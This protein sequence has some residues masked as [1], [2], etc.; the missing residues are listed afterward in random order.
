M[1]EAWEPS[2]I[3]GVLPKFGEHQEGKVLNITSVF[4]GH[5]MWVVRFE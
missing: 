2:N 5:L 1:D 3:C 4:R